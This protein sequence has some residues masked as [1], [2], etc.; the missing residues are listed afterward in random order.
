MRDMATGCMYR[1][2]GIGMGRYVLYY[3][4]V[5]WHG[6]GVGMGM[7]VSERVRGSERERERGKEG[8]KEQSRQST[9]DRAGYQNGCNC[10]GA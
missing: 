7:E 2:V 8:E 5:P 1:K 3:S 6:P 10:A 4:T 9:A